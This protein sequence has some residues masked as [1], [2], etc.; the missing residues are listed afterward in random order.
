M[1]HLKNIDRGKLEK[2]LQ[3]VLA[4][5]LEL[6]TEQEK[7]IVL[8]DLDE[9]PRTYSSVVRAAIKLQIIIPS[10]FLILGAVNQTDNLMRSCR[11]FILFL[12]KREEDN[13]SRKLI[14]KIEDEV[15]ENLSDTAPESPRPKKE[16]KKAKHAPD[17][18]NETVLKQSKMRKREAAD[19]ETAG[20]DADEIAKIPA[21]GD[22]DSTLCGGARRVSDQALLQ[23]HLVDAEGE[24]SQLRALLEAN[25]IGRVGMTMG[26]LRIKNG[27]TAAS[28]LHG[29]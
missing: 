26:L 13:R 11:E 22:E 27:H 4:N 29:L 25:G 24:D 21:S 28:A 3:G 8:P 1:K 23:K 14:I 2:V 7:S 18:K 6:S 9:V 5:M 20:A 16:S 15:I 17:T 19:N 12:R 10:R